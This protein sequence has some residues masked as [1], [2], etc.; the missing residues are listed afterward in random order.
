MPVSSPENNV[1]DVGYLVLDI[2]EFIA[3]LLVLSQ[4]ESGLAVV[5]DI[6]DFLWARIGK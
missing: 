3:L 4:N 1:L 5:Y 2:Q 6:G